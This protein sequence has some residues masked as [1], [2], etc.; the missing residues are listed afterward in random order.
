M[1]TTLVLLPGMDGT[2]DLFAP[3]IAAWKGPVHVVRYPTDTAL[4][5]Q[6]LTAF[7]RRANMSK[8]LKLT[9]AKP[10]QAA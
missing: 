10:L 1:K 9:H 8:P 7:A 3:F 2:G 6:E 4:N 5:Y